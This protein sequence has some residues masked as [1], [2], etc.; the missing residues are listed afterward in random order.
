VDTLVLDAFS[1]AVDRCEDESMAELL[2]SVRRLHALSVIE[3]DR[4]WYFEHGRMTGP[5]S[6]AVTRAIN[7]LCGELREHAEL[8]VDAFAIPDSQLAAPIAVD[9]D[10]T[11]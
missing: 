3:R 11:V 10:A 5:R 1:R 8:L 7:R 4:G 2:D 6:K 9:P